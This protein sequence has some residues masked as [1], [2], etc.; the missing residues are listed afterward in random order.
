MSIPFLST[1]LEY[2]G[3][4]SIGPVAGSLAAWF[5]AAFYGAAVPAGG[6]F[7]GSQSLAMGGGFVILFALAA[8]FF[9]SG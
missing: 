9:S 4:F 6:L 8:M 5:Q 2:L 3:F 1:H 7:A